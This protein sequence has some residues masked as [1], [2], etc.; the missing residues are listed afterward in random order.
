MA[1][2]V[3]VDESFFEEAPERYARTWSIPQ[4]AA[5]VWEE[6]IGEHP[7]HWCRGVNTTWTSPRPLGLGSTRTAKAFGG[8]LTISEFFFLWE[9]GRRYAFYGTE[10]NVPVFNSAAEDYVVESDGPDRCRLSWRVALA[11]AALGK[12]GRP[13][14]GVMFGRF[15][16][17]TGRYFGAA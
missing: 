13:L 6:L 3:P 9:E 2:L 7:L 4:P 17:D 15:F 1:R 11:P 14:N 8:V 16:K 12:L 5:R 10:A